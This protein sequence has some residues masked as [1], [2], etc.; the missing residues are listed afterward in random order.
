MIHTLPTKNIY[1]YRLHWQL[2]S[3]LT[4]EKLWY[5]VL[6]FINISVIKSLHDQ[7]IFPYLFISTTKLKTLTQ[8]KYTINPILS[9]STMIMYTLNY[10][11]LLIEL[12]YSYQ[13]WDQETSLHNSKN[14]W[15]KIGP[16]EHSLLHKYKQGFSIILE[17]NFKKLSIFCPL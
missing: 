15:L 16:N 13:S 4:C 9:T 17:M 11:R 1:I 5:K 3:C 14:R 10:S 7:T 6:I 2:D 12:I 8:T